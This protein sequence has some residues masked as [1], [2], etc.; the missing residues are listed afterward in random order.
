VPIADIASL[1]RSGNYCGLVEQGQL[2]C[3]SYW[4]TDTHPAKAN[5]A[6]AVMM[7]NLATL[8]NLIVDLLLYAAERS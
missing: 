5:V 2:F 3:L 6:I 4:G 8:A 7:M 1:I